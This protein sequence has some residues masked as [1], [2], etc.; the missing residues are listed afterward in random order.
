MLATAVEMT[1]LLYYDPTKRTSQSVLRLHNIAFVHAKLCF[2]H[3]RN[4]KT[5]SS[6]RM[7]GHYFHALTTHNPLLNRIIAPRLINTEMEE[8]MFGQCKAITRNTSNQHTNDIITNIL[9]RIQYE[10]K[11]LAAERNTV[12]NQES[13]IFKLAQTL[14]GKE[15]TVIPLGGFN[16]RLSIIKPT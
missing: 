6:R 3:F 8:R 11:S 14:S 4:P 12:K 16:I 2:D 1:E 13:E 15:N 7:F 10:D 9:V 5:M